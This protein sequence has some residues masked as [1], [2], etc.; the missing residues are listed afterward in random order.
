MKKEKGFVLWFTG[1]SQSG[2][3]T[4][5]DAVYNKLKEKG[6]LVERLDGDAVRQHLTSDLGFSKEDRIENIKRVA[7]LAKLLSRNGIMVIASFITPYEEQRRMLREE[8]D[9]YIEVFCS[10]PIE[11]CEKRDKKGLYKKARSGEVENFT[12]ISDLYDLPDNADIVLNTN[13]DKVED[14]IFLIASYLEKKK[15]I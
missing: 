4:T 2:K 12:G 8:I 15:M 7:F 9:N 13:D 1:L 3:T 10:C 11:V 6:F 5:A 14:N